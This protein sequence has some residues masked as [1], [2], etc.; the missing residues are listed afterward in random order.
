MLGLA[1]IDTFGCYL[2]NFHDLWFL[3]HHPIGVLLLFCAFFMF[4]LIN[5]INCCFPVLKQIE[6]IAPPDASEQW[7]AFA[8]NR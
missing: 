4:G 2:S 3:L 6:P 7:V 5:L 8:A 1:F